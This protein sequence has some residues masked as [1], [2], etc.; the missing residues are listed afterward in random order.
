MH[1]LEAEGI[2]VMF[3]DSAFIAA[4]SGGGPLAPALLLIRD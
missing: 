4:A 1:L 3:G 2:K